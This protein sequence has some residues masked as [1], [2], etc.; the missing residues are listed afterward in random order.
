[1]MME[2]ELEANQNVNELVTNDNKVSHLGLIGLA[3]MGYNLAYNLLYSGHTVSLYNKS[4]DR[5]DSMEEEYRKL[6]DEKEHPP[7]RFIFCYSLEEFVNSIPEPRPI[8]MIIQASAVKYVISDILPLISERDMICDFANSIPEHSLAHAKMISDF[9]HLN[10]NEAKFLGIGISGGTKGARNN[11]ALMISGN[12]ET[13]SYME[14][15]FS[16]L[17]NSYSYFGPGY[18]TGHFIKYLHNGIEYALMSTIAEFNEISCALESAHT[19]NVRKQT[20]SIL[21]DINVH[22]DT[23]LLTILK[24]VTENPSFLKIRNVLRMKGTGQWV[25]NTYGGRF[26]IGLIGNAVEQRVFRYDNS[27]DVEQTT[28]QN[29][30]QERV[31][32][33]SADVI[34]P[35]LFNKIKNVFLYCLRMCFLQG[36]DVILNEQQIVQNVSRDDLIRKA[37]HVWR[38]GCI[39]SGGIIDIVK[40]YYYKDEVLDAY[41]EIDEEA[42]EN[43]LKELVLFSIERNIPVQQTTTILNQLKRNSS[44]DNQ[45]RILAGMRDLFG[46]HGVDINGQW[47]N[48]VW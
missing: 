11:G 26:N 29:T 37:L 39:I 36:I 44:Q 30:S 18:A 23:Y 4:R 32:N 13:Y 12:S 20:S 24:I 25:F 27:A 41:L 8:F 40:H 7:G 14:N 2:P 46:M 16:S 9:F 43:D 28:N 6:L 34:Y 17:T 35:E 5:T 1:M 22:L 31:S 21:S 45:I 15:V 3:A 42:V 48:N 10:E 38:N 47:V 33:N 19:D